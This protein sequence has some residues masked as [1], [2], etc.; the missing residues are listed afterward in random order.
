MKY[1]ISQIKYVNNEF[2]SDHQKCLQKTK[3]LFESSSMMYRELWSFLYWQLAFSEFK[4]LHVLYKWPTLYQVPV[5]AAYAP[6]PSLKT[7]TGRFFYICKLQELWHWQDDQFNQHP[8]HGNLFPPTLAGENDFS[9]WESVGNW[10]KQLF[11][12]RGE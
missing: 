1:Q 7:N 8:E 11:L 10:W 2:P 9:I 3:L 12:K 4:L 5:I 6:V